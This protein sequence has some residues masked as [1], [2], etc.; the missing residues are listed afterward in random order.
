MEITKEEF[1]EKL[2]EFFNWA[3]TEQPRRLSS[4]LVSLEEWTK[5]QYERELWKSRQPNDAIMTSKS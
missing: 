4:W 3:H 1:Q 2:K 5:A